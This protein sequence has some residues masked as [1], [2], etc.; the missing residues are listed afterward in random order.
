M[1]FTLIGS[2]GFGQDSLVSNTTTKPRVFITMKEFHD[3][4]PSKTYSL[5][6]ISKSYKD[7]YIVDSV[8]GTYYCQLKD[9][10]VLKEGFAIL[11]SSNLFL[12]F[13]NLKDT[14]IF[15]KVDYAGRYPFYAIRTKSISKG[16]YGPGLVGLVVSAADAALYPQQP[17]EVIA[18]I[19]RKGNLTDASPVSI[20]ILLRKD[21]D[22]EK[23]YNSEKRLNNETFKKYLIKMNK[24]YPL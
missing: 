5:K 19:N 24:R 22:F 11:D 9:S 16:I 18:F 6:M 1:A 15:I 21:K 2:F 23:E 7:S 17:K 8:V 4:K 3:V 13:S 20:G 14:A 12:I 10:V